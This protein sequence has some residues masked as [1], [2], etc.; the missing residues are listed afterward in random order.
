MELSL[1]TKYAFWN[2]SPPT[3]PRHP[4]QRLHAISEGRYSRHSV[5]TRNRLCFEDS[6]SSRGGTQGTGQMCRGLEIEGGEATSE[7]PLCSDRSEGGISSL[8]P[9]NVN[10]GE[11]F[12]K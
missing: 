5:Q 3:S 4:R 1:S 6:N 12:A 7:R 8:N 9:R 10:F 2:A 11:S